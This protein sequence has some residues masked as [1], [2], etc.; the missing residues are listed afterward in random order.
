MDVIK[1]EMNFKLKQQL[2]EL[3]KMLLCAAIP[4]TTCYVRGCF[5]C[6]P[7]NPYIS[8]DSSQYIILHASHVYFVL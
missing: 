3:S 7:D 4:C 8:V 1:G 5:E 2:C 6:L